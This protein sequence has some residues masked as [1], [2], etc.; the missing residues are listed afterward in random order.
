MLFY[1]K[2]NCL[3]PSPHVDNWGT[4]SGV[5]VFKNF[6][7]EKLM[8]EIEKQLDSRYDT[9][10]FKNNL[11]NWYSNKIIDGIDGIHDLWE[12]VSE[13]LY[14]EWVIH[15][16][17]SLLKVLPGDNGMFVHSDSPGKDACH[18]LSQ[19]YNWSTC[20]LLDYGVVAYMGN[21]EGGAIFYPNIN[22][23]GTVKNKD[24]ENKPCTGIATIKFR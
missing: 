6:I 8:Q 13:L 14:P 19:I 17:N 2:K 16:T 1:D 21:W 23:D 11:M 10:D 3:N 15:P 4:K 18:L 22:P 5:F 9:V 24:S 7:P 20:C 12:T